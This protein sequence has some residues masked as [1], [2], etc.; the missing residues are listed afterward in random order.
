MNSKVATLPIL[1]TLIWALA[2][3]GCAASTGSWKRVEGRFPE[4]ICHTWTTPVPEL[5]AWSVKPGAAMEACLRKAEHNDTCSLTLEGLCFNIVASN[6]N[7][8]LHFDPQW[9]PPDVWFLTKPDGTSYNIGQDGV[10]HETRPVTMEEAMEILRKAKEA[11]EA[12][13]AEAPAP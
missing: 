8:E 5:F 4:G 9:C 7:F 12:E 6:G 10:A 2:S 3:T 11:E 13:K 1:A